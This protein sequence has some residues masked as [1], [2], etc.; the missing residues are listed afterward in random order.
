MSKITLNKTISASSPLAT[1]VSAINSNSVIIE[2][3]ANNN[4]SRDGTSPNT[5][6]ADLDMNSNQILNLPTPTSSTHVVRLGDLE[7]AIASATGL[8]DSDVFVLLTATQTLTNKTL[9][10]PTITG[11]LTN[12][13]GTVSAPSYTFTGDTGTGFWSPN[14]AEIAASLDGDELFR[15]TKDAGF[16]IFVIGHTAYT[17]FASETSGV[18]EPTLQVHSTDTVALGFARWSSGS[19]SGPRICLLKSRGATVGDYTIVNA[20]DRLGLIV[21]SG[22]DGTD[23][24]AGA[25]ITGFVDGTPGNNDMPGRL[26]F[27]TTADGANAPTDRLT[28]NSAGHIIALSATTTPPSLT[29][30]GQWVMTPTSNTNMRISYRGSDGTTRVGDITLA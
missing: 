12:A 1:I 14:D 26:V 19:S 24:A 11:V 21:F 13:L 20:N 7:E 2:E 10:S 28:I 4:L 23:A 30:N 18:I 25:T 6:R 9:A 15:L 17:N 27:A 29:T 8:E 16:P 22:T 3:E 5:M